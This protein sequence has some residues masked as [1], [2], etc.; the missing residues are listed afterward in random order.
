MPFKSKAQMRKFFE[1]E[2]KGEISRKEL[3]E[4]LDATP[5]PS[6]LPERVK[7]KKTKK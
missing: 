3:K 4:W 6:K 7:P 1:M 5:N 2:K